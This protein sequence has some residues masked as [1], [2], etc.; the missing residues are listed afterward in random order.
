MSTLQALQCLLAVQAHPTGVTSKSTR[1][2]VK[3]D[4]YKHGLS[5]DG[6]KQGDFSEFFEGSCGLLWGGRAKFRDSLS[7]PDSLHVGTPG[8]LR[9][10]CGLLSSEGSQIANANST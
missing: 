4:E 6:K 2:P 1:H 10:L 7:M 9:T 5:S 8:I 3:N